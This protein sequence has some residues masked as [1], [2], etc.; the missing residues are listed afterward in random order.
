MTK[1]MPVYFHISYGKNLFHL[2]QTLIFLYLF[3]L[4]EFSIWW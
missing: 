4:A 2:E 3:H 1:M